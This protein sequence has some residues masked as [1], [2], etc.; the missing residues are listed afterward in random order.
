MYNLYDTYPSNTLP[1]REAPR[2]RISFAHPQDLT[3]VMAP[4]YCHFLVCRFRRCL[5]FRVPPCGKLRIARVW[6]GP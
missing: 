2:M 3:V 5:I 6:N 1:C 4:D